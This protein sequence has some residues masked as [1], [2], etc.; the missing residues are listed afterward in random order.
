M[1]RTLSL[2]LA[3]VGLIGCRPGDKPSNTVVVY[4][5]VEM[6]SHARPVSNADGHRG[7][8][9]AD[10]EET[11]ST[12]LFNRLIAEGSS[13]RHG[14]WSGDPVRAAVLGARAPV[15]VKP[16]DPADTSG[17][18]SDPPDIA[19]SARARV[20]IVNTNSFPLPRL[21]A[22]ARLLEPK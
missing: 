20:L 22:A 14:F 1:K 6:S 16:A 15:P 3:L 5:S 7:E 13:G 21:R 17:R 18:F 11:K 4:T 9:G 10:T 8:T 2:L 12:G 19:L